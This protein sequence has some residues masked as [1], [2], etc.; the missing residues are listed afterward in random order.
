[1]VTRTPSASPTPHLYSR[2][3]TNR[4][5]TGTRR[6]ALFS[7]LAERRLPE[8]GIRRSNIGWA[9]A[10][11]SFRDS[12]NSLGWSRR[13]ANSPVNTAPQGGFLSS[14]QSL[15]PFGERGYV[16]LPTTE[17]TG[18]PLPA[19]SRREEEDAWFACESTR[20]FLLCTSPLSL[21]RPLPPSSFLLLRRAFHPTFPCLASRP[22]TL[23]PLQTASDARHVPI[24]HGHVSVCPTARGCIVSSLIN[25]VVFQFP[26]PA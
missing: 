8:R 23:L 14:L 18:A 11:T 9:M 1:M 20:I 21:L 22:R 17:P 25:F 10:S 7:S 2:L 4:N 6:R 26:F 24:L 19:P 12:I 5:A 3:P 16:Q 13:D 15:N